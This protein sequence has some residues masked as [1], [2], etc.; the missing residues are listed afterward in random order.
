MKIDFLAY[1]EAFARDLTADRHVRTSV[2]ALALAT[3]QHWSHWRH[4]ELQR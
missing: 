3:N 1:E 2:G 4:G